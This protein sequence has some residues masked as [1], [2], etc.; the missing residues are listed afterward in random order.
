MMAFL[1]RGDKVMFIIDFITVLEQYF[2]LTY[3]KYAKI[4]AY[5]L[6]L[7]KAWFFMQSQ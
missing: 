6:Q 3:Y 5:V 2:I 4:C 7:V 1:N